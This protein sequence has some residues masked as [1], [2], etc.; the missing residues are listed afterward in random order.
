MQAPSALVP[1]A[2]P[3]AQPT[4]RSE[5][6]AGAAIPLPV[7]VGESEQP[8]RT[9]R[10]REWPWPRG[11]SW[12]CRCCCPRPSCPAES[13]RSRRPEVSAG[14]LPRSARHPRSLSGWG[15]ARVPTCKAV[16]P[17]GEGS[18]GGVWE[19]PSP[20]VPLAAVGRARLPCARCL[21][22]LPGPDG[23]LTP[24]SALPVAG[25]PATRSPFPSLP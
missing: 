19:V 15:E 7:R 2:S 1:R 13:E 20:T 22:T 11:S 8:W 9:P 25:T 24:G 23:A 16:Q 14:Q 5:E 18:P 12:P 4:V 10:C 6:A 3:S 17:A 21:L